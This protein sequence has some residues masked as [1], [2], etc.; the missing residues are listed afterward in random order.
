MCSEALCVAENIIHPRLPVVGVEARS[1]Y[2]ATSHHRSQANA[3]A[4][5]ADDDDDDDDDDVADSEPLLFGRQFDAGQS[6]DHGDH[7]KPGDHGEP[8]ESGNHGDHSEPDDHSQSGDHGDP[9]EPDDHSE[10]GD[11]GELSQ[12]N[13]ARDEVDDLS[14]TEV[15]S[16]PQ[17]ALESGR[18]EEA[19][20]ELPAGDV[21]SCCVVEVAETV[22]HN[23]DS[24]SDATSALV[25]Q[26]PQ[27][28][29]PSDPLTSGS[30]SRPERRAVGADGP[31]AAEFTGRLTAV[32][33]LASAVPHCSESEPVKDQP[34]ECHPQS[35]QSS[36]KR[37]YG[38]TTSSANDDDEDSGSEAGEIEVQAYCC[39][40]V[41][42]PLCIAQGLYFPE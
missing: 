12:S 4:A 33:A 28:S 11:R 24:Q 9:G 15:H 10:P 3:A 36:R 8:G 31:S 35:Q 39:N 6:G 29:G 38:T 14:T 26:A 30:A 34:P 22:S 23:D 17:P 18:S 1:R 25:G 2:I 37:K 5:A 27:P 13:V 20:V 42:T 19:G 16:V 41:K 21:V 32:P 7:G 40:H